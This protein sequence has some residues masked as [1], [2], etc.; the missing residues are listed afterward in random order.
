MLF[1]GK[2]SSNKGGRNFNSEIRDILKE[3]LPFYIHGSN[4]S[5][6]YNLSDDEWWSEAWG[7]QAYGDVTGTYSPNRQ[8]QN[9]TESASGDADPVV[10]VYAG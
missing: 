9:D 5:T 8:S 1:S 7:D 10:S 4:Q 3:H 6:T 2:P